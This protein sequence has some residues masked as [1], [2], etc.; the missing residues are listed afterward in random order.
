MAPSRRPPRPAAP[1]SGLALALRLRRGGPH[2]ERRTTTHQQMRRRLDPRRRRPH[3][4]HRRRHIRSLAGSI[5]AHLKLPGLA[6]RAINIAYGIYPAWPTRVRRPRVA[7]H[8][9]LPRCHLRRERVGSADRPRQDRLR[10]RRG[11]HASRTSGTPS[12]P[13]ATCS[14]TT[15]SRSR[16]GKGTD[17]GRRVLSQAGSPVELPATLDGRHTP[18]ERLPPLAVEPRQPPR[19]PPRPA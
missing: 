1:P 8:E 19:Q 11:A 10:G 14:G 17:T 18:Q 7:A 13:T 5:D 4:R 15:C 16:A 12:V 3:A 9:R 6:A 2:V